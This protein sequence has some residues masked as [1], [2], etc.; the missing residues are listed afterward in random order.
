MQ[1]YYL[2]L[3]DSQRFTFERKYYPAIL[4]ELRRYGASV[5]IQIEKG[6]TEPQVFLING[7]FLSTQGM[8]KVLR[9]LWKDT[10]NY[11]IG[12]QSR[13]S[14]R[15]GIR[16]SISDPISTDTW[17]TELDKFFNQGGTNKITTIVKTQQE[18]IR[19]VINKTIEEGVKNGDGML[20]IKRDLVKKLK[21]K[22]WALTSRF[23]A[24]RIVQT[25][26]SSSASIAGFEQNKRLL[27]IVRKYWIHN[28]LGK[29]R[30]SHIDAASQYNKANAIE[31]D[32]PFMIDGGTPMMHPHDSMGG[33]ANV[34]NCY[35]TQGTVLA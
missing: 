28:G 10:G 6:L 24:S 4:K 13:S 26:V 31:L 27:G 32:M 33:A 23:N 9:T 20:N 25:E 3:M 14:K 7:T 17:E 5:A 29:P 34:I 8:D 21:G 15:L 1:I 22:E 2:C 12:K 19:G 35:C 11:Y 30:L 18:N 16:G